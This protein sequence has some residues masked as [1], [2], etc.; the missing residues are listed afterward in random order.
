VAPSKDP[1]TKAET[2]KKRKVS[3]KK[4]STRKKSRANKPQLQI[5][6]MVDEINLIIAVISNVSEDI[7][8]QNEA[9]H[10]TM[11]DRIEVELKG[12]Q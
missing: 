12:V 2:S 10:E 5:V 1:L 7:L 11:Y 8:Q 4:P 6:L 9:K 3:P